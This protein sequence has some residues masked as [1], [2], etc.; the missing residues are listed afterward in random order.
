MRA[1]P[2]GAHPSLHGE[3]PAPRDRAGGARRFHALPVRLAARLAGFAGARGGGAGWC[4]QPAGRLPGRGRRLGKRHPA[5]A[6]VRLWHQLAGRPV[7]RRPAG[8]GTAAVAL[9]GQSRSRRPAAQHTHRAAATAATGAVERIV[10]RCGGAGAVGESRQ[11]AGNP[12][13]AGGAVL[14]RTDRGNA[15]AAHRAGNRARR[16]GGG[17]PGELRQL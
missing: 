13:G 12:E 6:R 17:R 16:T 15:P 1:S 7:P 9:D 14:R 5:A 4:A 2:A 8:L 3:A 10:C 11:G